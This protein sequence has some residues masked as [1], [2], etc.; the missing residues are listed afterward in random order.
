MSGLTNI[1][2]PRTDA[3]STFLVTQ[4]PATLGNFELHK[5]L[6]EFE[7]LERELA[8]AKQ[9][10]DEWKVIAEGLAASLRDKTQIPN[11]ALARFNA[12]KGQT[13]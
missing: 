13:K 2:T 1:P 7:Q 12:K 3:L 9:G 11:A 4:F 6:T 8:E 5:R 10:C